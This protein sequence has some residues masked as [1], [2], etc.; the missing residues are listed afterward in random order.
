MTNRPQN[1]SSY[2]FSLAWGPPCVFHLCVLHCRTSLKPT[3][4]KPKASDHATEG[5]TQLPKSQGLVTWCKPLLHQLLHGYLTACL[6]KVCV[7]SLAVNQSQC[8][9]SHS[10]PVQEPLLASIDTHTHTHTHTHVS[11]TSSAA[12]KCSTM[13]VQT[14]PSDL[15]SLLL[16]SSVVQGPPQTQP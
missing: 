3:L 1:L 10:F 16:D 6:R 14:K 12:R 7:L 9:W 11:Y 4:G 13:C 8:K 15:A 5:V 2:C